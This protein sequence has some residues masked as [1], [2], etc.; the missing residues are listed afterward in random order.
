MLLSNKKLVSSSQELNCYQHVQKDL[1]PGNIV[2]ATCSVQSPVVLWIIHTAD[3]GS[4]EIDFNARDAVGNRETDGAFSANLTRH[5]PSPDNISESVLQYVYTNELNNTKLVCA[6][7]L[8]ETLTQS[9][10]IFS[11]GT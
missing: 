6:N 2:T 11:N 10:Q 9:C 8:N 3:S 4:Y 5:Y 1:C 7:L